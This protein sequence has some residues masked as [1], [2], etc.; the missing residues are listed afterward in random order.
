M[1]S[2]HIPRSTDRS[3]FTGSTRPIMVIN[4]SPSHA[5]FVKLFISVA[6]RGRSNKC[7]HWLKELFRHNPPYDMPEVVVTTQSLVALLSIP[8]SHT[9][10][11]EFRLYCVHFYFHHTTHK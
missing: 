3:E 11:I 7:Q 8:G 10:Q 6:Q 9:L 4:K 2:R 5:M 1:I